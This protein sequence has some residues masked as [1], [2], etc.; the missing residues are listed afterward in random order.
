MSTPEWQD[1]VARKREQRAS[2]IPQQWL[3]KKASGHNP[4]KSLLDSG[5]LTPEEMEPT[6]VS[7]HDAVE[8]LSLVASGSITAEKLV[9]SFCKRAAAADSL[10]NFITEV[11]FEQAIRRAKELDKHLLETDRVVGPLHGLPITVKDH[12][13]L[14]GH[15]SSAGIA[16]YCFDPAKS[17]SRLVQIMVE[18]GAVVVAKTNVPQTCLAADTIN[19]VFGR[20]LNAHD[21]GFGAG[22]SSGGEGSALALAMGASLLGLGSDGAGSARMPA[23]AN[24]VVGYRPSGYRL[25]AD[26]RSILDPGMMGITELGPVATFGLMGHSIRDIRLASKVVSDARQWEHDPFLYTSPWLGITAPTRPRIGV[27]VSD[28]PNNYCHLFSPVLRGYLTAQKRL[29]QAGYELVEFTPP[30]MSEVWE[31]CGTFIHVQGITPLT[32]EIAKEPIM[33]IVEKTGTLGSEWANKRITLED[34]HQLNQKLALLNIQMKAAWNASGRPLDALLW[35][36]APNPALPIDEW[37]DTTF[38]AV[39][40]AVDWP[41]ISLPLGMKCDQGVDASYVDFKPFS[42]EDARL[43]A[44]YEPEKFHGLPLSVQLAGQ[45]FEDEKLLAIAE[46]ITSVVRHE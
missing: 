38:T 44:I 11:N 12:M 26:G 2:L 18:A 4:L 36:T 28:T 15:D 8:T 14:E 25:P 32:K 29:R 31:L 5:I 27:W 1:I 37:T 23:M 16:A 41:A 22:G 19:V 21:S 17:N 7:K 43:Q 46:L 3:I 20:T 39:F 6:D 34:V 10:T 42:T 40:N 30:D 45:R 9:T 35:V 24:G 13:D 33:K